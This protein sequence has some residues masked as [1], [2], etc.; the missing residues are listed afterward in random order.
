MNKIPP[1]SWVAP[2]LRRQT[3]MWVNYTETV[4]SDSIVWLELKGSGDKEIWKE[5]EN[6]RH[7][8]DELD[9][10]FGKQGTT[11][12]L[13]NRIRARYSHV[14]AQAASAKVETRNGCLTEAELTG[15]RLRLI[16]EK[17]TNSAMNTVRARKG[18][19]VDAGIFKKKASPARAWWVTV[20]DLWSKHSITLCFS[21]WVGL[22]VVARAIERDGPGRERSRSNEKWCRLT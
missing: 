21:P 2:C 11:G 12:Y 8:V 20:G 6:R 16:Q 22:G 4:K 15:K 17:M 18:K 9:C 19:V 5:V 10:D 7:W 1:Y 14:I 13:K 3:D